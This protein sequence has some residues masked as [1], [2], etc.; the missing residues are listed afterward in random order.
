MKWVV[1]L[2]GLRSG[3][4]VRRWRDDIGMKENEKKDDNGKRHIKREGLNI[5]TREA[6]IE[7][8][9]ADAVLDHHTQPCRQW[10]C[11]WLRTGKRHISTSGH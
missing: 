3:K 10:Y 6:Q 8:Y 1:Q 5:S 2:E 9:I 4:M 11:A 7:G